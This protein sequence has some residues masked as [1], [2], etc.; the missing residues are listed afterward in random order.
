MAKLTMNLNTTDV[1]EDKTIPKALKKQA[2][3]LPSPHREDLRGK[4]REKTQL[5]FPRIPVFLKTMF[6]EAAREA[7]MKDIEFLYHLMRRHGL[8]VPPYDQMDLRKL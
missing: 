7:E 8:D 6:Q 1:E 2:K 4:L 5:N 3:S